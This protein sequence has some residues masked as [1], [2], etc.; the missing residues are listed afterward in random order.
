MNI[1]QFLYASGALLMLTVLAACSEKEDD[2]A[3]AGGAGEITL[4]SDAIE[5]KT[6]EENIVPL[7]SVI[8]AGAG[9]YNAYSLTPQM[10]EIVR[11][12]DGRLYIKALQNGFGEIMIL[13]ANNN[14]KRVVLTLY[15]YDAI[16]FNFD[17]YDFKIRI[18]ERATTSA[19]EVIEGN[20]NYTLSSDNDRIDARIEQSGRITITA[21]AAIE[22]F[23]ATLTVTDQAGRSGDITVTVMSS[24]DSFTDDE[25]E[26][27]RNTD[28]S[29]I[30]S[31][32]W[33]YIDAY[34]SY[35]TYASGYAT[36]CTAYFMINGDEGGWS[37]EDI[38]GG[39]HSL[40]FQVKMFS[41]WYGKH[42]IQYPTGTGLDKEV[43]A[44]YYVENY[45]KADPMQWK[46]KAKILR[47]DGDGVIVI[48]YNFDEVNEK[49][50][51]GWV[52]YP[53]KAMAAYGK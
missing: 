38:G 32:D 23:V 45:N 1:K 21:T 6:G 11:G 46:G 31:F 8:A 44:T 37:D 15:T 36:G 33:L 9:A 48:W 7:D 53:K 39:L 13:D 22:D 17:S 4:I 24:T 42:E 51:R 25:I 34:G 14:Y 49:I 19:L 27:L 12:D 18:G 2:G 47:N 30:Y 52:I 10:C 29:D 20:G 28:L 35:P 40:K 41:Y 50:E 5:V 3:L 16:I 43:E 26:N